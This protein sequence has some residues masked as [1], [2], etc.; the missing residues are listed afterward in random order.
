[1]TIDPFSVQVHS[2]L[3]K[4]HDNHTPSLAR[5]VLTR[6][7]E[8]SGKI[9]QNQHPMNAGSE[10]AGLVDSARCKGQ[11]LTSLKDLYES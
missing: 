4:I 3:W 9:P 8:P 1:M 11:L 10:T 2:V 6:M 5:S 7:K